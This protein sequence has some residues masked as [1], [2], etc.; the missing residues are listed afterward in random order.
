[1]PQSARRLLRET[2]DQLPENAS[3]EEAIERLL[4]VA[5][6]EQ[7]DADAGRTVSHDE[8]EARLGL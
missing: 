3:V 2:L 8:V 4:F 7:G 1:M 5:D 6:I